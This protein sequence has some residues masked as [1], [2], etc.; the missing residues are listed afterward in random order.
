M[1]PSFVLSPVTAADLPRLAEIQH[2]AFGPADPL[3]RATSANVA[4][5]AHI[6][7]L[8]HGLAH[9]DPAPGT[10]IELVCARDVESGVIGGWARWDIPLGEGEAWAGAATEKAPLPEGMDGALWDEFFGHVTKHKARLMGDRSRWRTYDVCARVSSLMAHLAQCSTSWSS[11]PLTSDA[12]SARS[13]SR[14]ALGVR[15]PSVFPSSS[16]PRP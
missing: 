8:A 4:P 2:D 6:A 16:R 12:A 1:P 9:P 7:W 3:A 13:S 15:M 5:A 10:R 11:T 14:T